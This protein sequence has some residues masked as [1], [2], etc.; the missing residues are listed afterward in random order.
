MKTVINYIV[1]I[2]HIGGVLEK[3]RKSSDFRF[4]LP[5]RPATHYEKSPN[6]VAPLPY[7]DP[8]QTGLPLEMLRISWNMAWHGGMDN[9]LK[10]IIGSRQQAESLEE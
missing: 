1:F 5:F 6:Q 10:S 4:R 9:L 7:P 2:C 8:L 3:K